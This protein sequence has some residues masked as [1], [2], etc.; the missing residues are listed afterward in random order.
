MN[1]IAS[2]VLIINQFLVVLVLEDE[3]IVH[4]VIANS[5][6]IPD[7]IVANQALEDRPSLSIQSSLI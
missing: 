5:I 1:V 7:L 4:S 3:A 6:L 2:I